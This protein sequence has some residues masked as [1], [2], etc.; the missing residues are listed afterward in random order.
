MESFIQF[1][2][3]KVPKELCSFFPEDRYSCHKLQIAGTLS[4]LDNPEFIERI[5]KLIKKAPD[6]E[7]EQD[8]ADWYRIFLLRNRTVKVESADTLLSI[9]CEA[10]CNRSDKVKTRV[11]EDVTRPEM[12]ESPENMDFPLADREYVSRQSLIFGVKHKLRDAEPFVRCEDCRGSG[13]AKCERCDGTGRE[14]YV[15]GTYANGEERIRT[16]ACPDCGGRGRVP[17][18]KCQGDGKIEIYAPE[19]SVVKSVE[20]TCYHHM[21]VQ[22]WTPWQPYSVLYCESDALED[23]QDEDPSDRCYRSSAEKA[24]NAVF[25]TLK[26]NVVIRK[27]NRN[28]VLLDRT[29]EVLAEVEKAGLH[30]AYEKNKG[31]CSFD[32]NNQLVERNEAHIVIPTKRVTISAGEDS[33]K[34]LAYE[35]AANQLQIVIPYS[36]GFMERGK[37]FLLRFYYLLVQVG[38]L[39]MRPFGK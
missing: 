9:F 5:L 33:L 38:K 1:G 23:E 19:Y 6:I 10:Y 4:N 16:G 26:N 11:E 17:C 39:V 14:Q 18:P 12:L 36:L 35:T 3:D 37:F 21:A 31:R 30:T 27:K 2:Y 28:T 25:S 22:Y 20:E 15:D 29:E 32:D 7:V 13:M 8:E 34:F 24:A